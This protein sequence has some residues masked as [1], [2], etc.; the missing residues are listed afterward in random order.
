MGHLRRIFIVI[1]IL[2]ICHGNICRSPMAEFILKKM[3]MEP[4]WAEMLPEGTQFHI[5]SAA[6][7]R[8]E[9]G[10]D[11]YPPA[12]AKLREMDVPFEQ[13]RARQM[14]PAEYEEYDFIIGM[15]DANIR[16]ICRMCSFA[17][18]SDGKRPA[19]PQHKI[20]KI[21]DFAG[22][23]RSVSDP[24]YTGD[25]A[26]TY[27]DVIMGCEGFLNFLATGGRHIISV[28]TMCDSDAYTIANITP[29]KELMYR[30]GKSIFEGVCWRTPV[31][32]VCGKGNN[33]GDG[34]V[35]AGL[36]KD[37]GVDCRIF[38]ID[39]NRFSGDGAYYFEKCREKCIP[40]EQFVGTADDTKTP[41][42]LSAYGTI[43]DCLLGTGFAG[44]VRGITAEAINEINRCGEAG[45]YIVSADI[46][47]GLNGDTGEGSLFVKSDLTVSIGDYKYGHFMGRADEAM[48]AKVNCD[49]GI[50]LIG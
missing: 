20:Y 46:N 17:M 40:Y 44:D 42:D 7:S 39:E 30:A 45:A 33:A 4:R 18:D 36:L 41:T 37:A 13:R 16:N 5:E 10:N 15:D 11:I 6:T 34:Y 47:S 38:L 3:V 9:I 23:D 28:K 49:I 31:A 43:L 19:D 25:F 2:F 50:E 24:W 12:K 27:Q 48:K 26:A 35:V 29:S 8:E 14:T 21:L 22:I 1:K 32:I